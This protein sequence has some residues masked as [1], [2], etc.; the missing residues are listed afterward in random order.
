MSAELAD[1]KCSPVANEL[2]EYDLECF[3]SIGFTLHSDI[4]LQTNQVT[5]RL[6]SDG[7]SN[8]SQR[9]RTAGHL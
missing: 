4:I 3:L 2:T 7:S 6:F 8:L 1:L 9:K 5:E